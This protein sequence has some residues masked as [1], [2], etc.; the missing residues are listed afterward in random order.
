VN[1]E[2][3]HKEIV[4]AYLAGK[5]IQM[6][7]DSGWMDYPLAGGSQYEPSCLPAFP[8]I[9]TF[10]IKPPPPPGPT[11]YRFYLG[12]SGFIHTVWIRRDGELRTP[13]N[14]TEAEAEKFPSFVRWVSPLLTLEV[15]PTPDPQPNKYAG[16]SY[17]Y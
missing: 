1:K 14:T 3:P 17:Y 10:R 9:H 4:L 2:Y 7:H 15:L 11:Q 16:Y 12:R 8:A 13:Q 5:Q 6:L